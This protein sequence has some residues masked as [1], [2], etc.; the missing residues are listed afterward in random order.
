MVIA[1]RLRSLSKFASVAVCALGLTLGLPSRAQAISVNW[2]GADN[3]NDGTITFTPFLA[4][5]LTDILGSGEYE[6]CCRHG[7]T[8]FDLKLKLDGIW[9]EIF[10]WTATGDNITHLLGDLVPPEYAFTTAMVSGIR[11]QSSPN[12]ESNDPNFT[13][14]KFTSY[15]SQHDY[16]TH[17]KS[18]YD[19]RHMS[20]DDYLKCGDYENYVKH[21]TTFVFSYVPPPV[22][23]PLPAALPLFATGL[24][25]IGLIAWRRKRKDA[26]A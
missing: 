23:T 17:N 11:L 22:T 1:S 12:G 14:F 20:Y 18:Y 4:N 21:V 19:D 24:G 13:D 7:V 3:F 26:A 25:V 9:T 6:A 15:L 16:Y 2:T 8:N 10:S 5:Q